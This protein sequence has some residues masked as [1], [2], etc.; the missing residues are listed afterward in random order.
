MIFRNPTFDTIPRLLTNFENK[1]PKNLFLRIHRS[2]IIAI[3]KVNTIEGNRV[4]IGKNEIPVG[5]VYKH[6]LIK[7]MK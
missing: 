7:F 5:N 2:Y 3:K 4:K 6:N 1:L